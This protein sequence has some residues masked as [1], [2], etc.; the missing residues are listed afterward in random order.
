VALR[1]LCLP[2]SNAEVERVF[3][4]MNIVKNKIRNKMKLDLLNNILNIKYGLKRIGKCCNSFNLPDEV[5][6]MFDTNVAYKRTS[7]E[8]ENLDVDNILQNLCVD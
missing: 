1:I 6:L 7:H 3:S 2:H 5:L 4:S 8:A